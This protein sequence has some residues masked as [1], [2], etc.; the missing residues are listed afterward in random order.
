MTVNSLFF[1]TLVVTIYQYRSTR[2]IIRQYRSQKPLKLRPKKNRN[3][4]NISCNISGTKS[5]ATYENYRK[6]NSWNI[7]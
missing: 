4:Q 2:E 7:Y 5:K 1:P 3:G 6:I